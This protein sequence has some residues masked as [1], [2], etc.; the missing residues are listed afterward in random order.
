M[1]D[2][3]SL[4]W[5]RFLAAAGVSELLVMQN[6]AAMADVMRAAFFAARSEAADVSLKRA[7]A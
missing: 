5:W 1:R 7:G 2:S 6:V 3:A 4:P